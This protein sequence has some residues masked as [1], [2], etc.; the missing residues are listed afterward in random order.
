MADFLTPAER[1]KRMSKIRSRGNASTEL[2][3][4]AL[5]RAARIS[6]WRRNS[7]LPGRPD[8]VFRKTKVVIFVDGCFW[9]GCRIHFVPPA[10]NLPFWE[11]KIAR[12]IARD[13]VINRELRRAGWT[14]VRI[15]EHELKP[16]SVQATARKLTRLLN[17]RVQTSTPRSP[18]THDR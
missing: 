18:R 5:F 4:I 11:K 9:H 1:S 14:V 8:F 7:I 13:R 12:N 6:G 15:W 2:R 3:L 16:A 10:T 17:T